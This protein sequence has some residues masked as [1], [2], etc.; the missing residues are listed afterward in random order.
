MAVEAYDVFNRTDLLEEIALEKM[1]AKLST[2][3]Y[4][5]GLEPVGSRSRRRP[6]RR[7]SRQS[8]AGSWH[9][10]RGRWPS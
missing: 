6:G 3:R 2:R 5:A 1:M 7:R 4:S 10:P 8:A 9:A